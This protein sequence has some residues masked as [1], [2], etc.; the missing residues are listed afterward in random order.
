VEGEVVVPK[1]IEAG[2]EIVR[3]PA[4]GEEGVE[5]ERVKSVAFPLVTASRE[6]NKLTNK[7][8]PRKLRGKFKVASI[9]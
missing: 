1:E 7:I 8:F 6:R 5:I 2:T 9:H 4:G 3:L